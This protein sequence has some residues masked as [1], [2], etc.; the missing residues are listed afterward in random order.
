MIP[1]QDIRKHERNTEGQDRAIDENF[2]RLVSANINESSS[3][4]TNASLAFSSAVSNSINI[5][6]ADSKAVSDS[7]LASTADSKAVS[8]GITGSTSDS[9]SSSKNLSQS[10]NVSTADSKAVSTSLNTPS[11]Y[12]EGTWTPTLGGNATYTIQIGTYTQ[13]GRVI[14][15]QVRLKVN[16]L[17]TGSTSTI[18]GLPVAVAT[19]DAYAG[20][21]G[22]WSSL[23]GLYTYVGCYVHGTTVI[24]TGSLVAAA[25]LTAPAGIFANGADV[26]VTI[27]YNV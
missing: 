13:I 5:S 22:Y 15:A 1:L 7:A 21:V 27:V 14:I 9:S 4:S 25:S 16:S 12:V 17:G 11:S 6:V 26:L 2:R 20:S 18:S 3:V 19:D 8:V 24:F 23:S 10:S